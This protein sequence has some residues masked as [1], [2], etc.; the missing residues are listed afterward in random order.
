MLRP[1]TLFQVDAE[2]P[3]LPAHQRAGG[4]HESVEQEPSSWTDAIW[5]RA[6]PSTVRYPRSHQNASAIRV[7]PR[8]CFGSQTSL[9]TP[10]EGHHV[11]E[12]QAAQQTGPQVCSHLVPRLE[13]H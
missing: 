4:H 7:C 12:D 13:C 9:E 8:G 2:W 3:R 10:D 1:P 6:L 11:T 5:A